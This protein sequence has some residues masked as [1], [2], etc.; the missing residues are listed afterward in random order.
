MT[1]KVGPLILAIL[2]VSVRI[3]GDQGPADFIAVVYLA[4]V[5]LHLY[6]SPELRAAVRAV[7]P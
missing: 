2:S 7:R 6:R 4:S 3:A 1:W 5:T